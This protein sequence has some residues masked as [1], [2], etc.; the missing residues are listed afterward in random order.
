MPHAKECTRPSL[1]G[2]FRAPG[3][4]DLHDTPYV[5]DSEWVY[6]PSTAGLVAN[7]K[8]RADADVP[9]GAVHNKEATQGTAPV[10]L[11]HTLDPW[12]WRYAMSKLDTRTWR[13]IA[14]LSCA[15]LLLVIIYCVLMHEAR[16][17]P[18]EFLGLEHGTEDVKEIKRAYRR[19]CNRYH[20][21]MSEG[22]GEDIFAKATRAYEV[23]TADKSCRADYK[24]DICWA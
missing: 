13:T 15:L 18:F 11:T 2:V 1:R 23:L 6:V 12:T 7:M 10:S 8:K 14:A 5:I 24:Q 19:V 9:C 20:H 22:T 3:A 21:D 4:T 16:F 17:D